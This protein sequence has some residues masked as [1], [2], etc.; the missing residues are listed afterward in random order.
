MGMGLTGDRAQPGHAHDAFMQ[1]HAVAGAG[2][3]MPGTAQK[4]CPDCGGPMQKGFLVAESYLGG[5]KWAARRTRLAAS[6]ERLVNPDA[7][8]NVYIAGLRCARCRYL[9]LRY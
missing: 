7:W 8:G 2:G 5:A 6:G 9:A 3:W 4:V 1:Q